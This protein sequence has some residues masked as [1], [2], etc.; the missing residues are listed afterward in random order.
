MEVSG[1]IT[2]LE[3]AATELGVNNKTLAC[4][5]GQLAAYAVWHT[6]QDKFHLVSTGEGCDGTEV[7]LTA[8][9]RTEDEP[10]IKWTTVSYL[11]KLLRD[12]MRRLC[13]MD[14]KMYGSFDFFPVSTEMQ[15]LQFDPQIGMYQGVCWLNDIPVKTHVQDVSVFCSASYAKVGARLIKEVKDNGTY[16][17]CVISHQAI[18][19][20]LGMDDP[21]EDDELLAISVCAKILR[22]PM[23]Y[24]GQ[25]TIDMDNQAVFEAMRKLLEIADEMGERSRRGNHWKNPSH[26]RAYGSACEFLP[27]CARRHSPD[28]VKYKPRDRSESDLTRLSHSRVST[29]QNC[30]RKHHYRYEYNGTGIELVDFKSSLSARRGNCWGRA[31]D[32]LYKDNCKTVSINESQQPAMVVA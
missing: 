13:V 14:H 16:R 10:G 12:P 11:D 3:N 29:Y 25:V 27:I 2:E 24:F 18:D 9:L 15:M 5:K 1:A 4:L 23:K 30:S 32:R 6:I 21:V 7:K 22:T 8:E 17:G 26:C 28:G 20:V 19:Q 31:L